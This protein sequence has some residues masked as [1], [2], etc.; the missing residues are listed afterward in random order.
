MTAS[1]SARTGCLSAGYAPDSSV[2]YAFRDFSFSWMAWPAVRR[3]K[4]IFPLFR[5][6]SIYRSNIICSSGFVFL[7]GVW[8]LRSG[9]SAVLH[10]EIQ[11]SGGHRTE[12]PQD[13]GAGLFCTQNQRFHRVHL[14]RPD[15]VSNLVYSSSCFIFLFS[16]SVCLVFWFLFIY[17]LFCMTAER[18]DPTLLGKTTR[19]L[20]QR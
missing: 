11:L 16:V 12:G 7:L 13:K 19:S 18:K 14:R 4:Q 9:V 15:Q 8:S 6:P 20:H 3:K 10:P 17:L 5:R 2:S 1:C